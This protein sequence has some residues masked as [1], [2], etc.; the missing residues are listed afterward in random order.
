MILVDTNILLRLVQVGH[1]HCQVAFDALALLATQD[2]EH[3]AVAPQC[4]Y[5]LYVVATRPI[6]V[7][8]LGLTAHEGQA[9]IVKALALFPLLPETSHVFHTW[10]TLIAK[11]GVIGKTAHDT[12]LVA[13]MIEHRLARVLTFNDSDFRRYTEIEPLNPFDVLGIPRS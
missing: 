10:E 11:Y 2:Q 6:A 13:M 3:F 1:A 9:E 4:L 12:R 8:G 5:E 7:Q